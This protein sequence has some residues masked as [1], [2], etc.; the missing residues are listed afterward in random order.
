[1]TWLL[2][3]AYLL[4]LALAAPWLLVKA[5]RQGK[6][7]H[8][9][10]Q[11]L[12]G[13]VPQR[14]AAWGGIWF[15]GVSVGEINALAGIIE[16]FRRCCP[17]LPCAVSTTTRT[18]YELACRRFSGLD[19]FY[20]PLDFSWAVQQALTRQRPA[21]L[22]LAELELWPNLIALARRQGVRIAVVNGRL[23][24]RS[25]RGY[26]RLRPLV[27]RWLAQVDLVAAQHADYAAR[28][29]A[30]GAP[31]V[32]VTGSVKFDGA[33]NDRQHPHVQRLRRLAGLEDEHLVWLAGSTHAP[34]E[35]LVLEAFAPLARQFPQLR[36]L[37]A[38]RHP[39]RYAS[40]CALLRASGLSWRRRTELE[41]SCAH[42]PPAVILIDT[43]GELGWWWGTADIAFVGGSLSRRGGQNMIEP[44]AYG[45]AVAF[46]PNTWN[47]RDVSEAL[48]AEQAAVVVHSAEELA[49]FVRRCI[50]E[51]DYRLSLGQRARELVLAQRG[52][53]QRTCELLME[54]LPPT[55][56][57]AAS[58]PAQEAA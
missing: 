54:L 44:A 10:A 13:R 32:E 28:F 57:R 1:M 37:L 19:V 50:V 27:A 36:L 29:R 18:G 2:N 34:E 24:E 3:A 45:A 30:L 12:L 55:A 35:R 46:G 48:K 47:F 15:H 40:V 41:T 51:P 11:K 43:V 58:T 7:R 38:P 42:A 9:L 5:L 33:Q 21:M 23:S 20:M 16:H 25:F 39:E 26:S 22:V 17:D 14:R 8:G 31:R 6:Y 52:A 49:A 53:Q 56:P 4:L